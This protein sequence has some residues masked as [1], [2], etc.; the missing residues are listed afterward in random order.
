MAEK[1]GGNHNST[2][3]KYYSSIKIKQLYSLSSL[4]PEIGSIENMYDRIW[5]SSPF[6]PNIIE[7]IYWK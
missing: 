6:F 4:E 2:Q 3:D 7:Y 5:T 1:N